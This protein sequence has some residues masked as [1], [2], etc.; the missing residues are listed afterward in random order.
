[1]TLKPAV[2]LSSVWCPSTVHPSGQPAPPSL[3]V[4][5]AC[6]TSESN[7]T[8]RPAIKDTHHRIQQ[9]AAELRPAIRRIV[10]T[11]WCPQTRHERCV[12]CSIAEHCAPGELRTHARSLMRRW[13]GGR[14]DAAGSAS[15]TFASVTGT[16]HAIAPECGSSSARRA[17]PWAGGSI[18]QGG[19]TG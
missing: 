5:S 12:L 8:F 1:M 19:P 7:S 3:A 14:L 2:A 18:A 9:E 10:R 6:S 13:T 17:T 15:E 4:R 11:A 16:R